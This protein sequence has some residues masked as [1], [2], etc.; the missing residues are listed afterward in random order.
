MTDNGYNP[1]EPWCRA[2]P[3]NVV[4]FSLIW[5]GEAF[6]NLIFVKWAIHG[7]AALYL[8]LPPWTLLGL[9]MVVRPMWIV[10]ME[11]ALWKALE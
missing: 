5:L 1:N 4:I 3:K 11:R 6:L 8:I 7:S 9:I 10:G 2:S